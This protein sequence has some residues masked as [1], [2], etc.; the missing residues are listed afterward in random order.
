MVDEFEAVQLKVVGITEILRKSI[1]KLNEIALKPNPLST[2]EY[3]GILIE[4]EKANAEPGFLDRINHLNEVKKK[5]EHL[6]NVTEQGY[7]PFEVYKRKIK[8]E[9]DEKAGVWSA[10]GK[11]LNKIGF[12]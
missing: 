8:Q 6:A 12:M 4:S 1:N 11:Y 2:G 10:V 3:I 7:D 9:K 5:V